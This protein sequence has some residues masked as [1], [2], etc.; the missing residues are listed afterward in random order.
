MVI[1]NELMT[2]IAGRFG[3]IEPRRAASA[4]DIFDEAHPAL[5]QGE[6]PAGHS[7]ADGTRSILRG[8]S[9]PPAARLFVLEPT[10]GAC[11]ATRA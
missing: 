11:V 2:P 8:E 1:F 5:A 7:T 10:A 6:V 9:A 4:A 3:R